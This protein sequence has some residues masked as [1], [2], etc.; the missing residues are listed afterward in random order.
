MPIVN[1]DS[2]RCVIA[3]IET[4]YFCI[5]DLLMQYTLQ[6]KI[7]HIKDAYGV[8]INIFLQDMG[9]LKNI[10]MVHRKG[11]CLNNKFK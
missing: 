9:H 11:F 3:S 1:Q 5:S 7:L 10:A 2:W 4:C 6:M 8:I